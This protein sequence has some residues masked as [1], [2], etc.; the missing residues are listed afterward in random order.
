MGVKD[1]DHPATGRDKAREASSHPDECEAGVQNPLTD[2]AKIRRVIQQ[3]GVS[4]AIPWA[5]SDHNPGIDLRLAVRR[6]GIGWSNQFAD[7]FGNRL[8][9]NVRLI[10]S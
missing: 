4:D 1:D 9:A 5:R 3:G 8:S 7:A 10:M 6:V 2:R